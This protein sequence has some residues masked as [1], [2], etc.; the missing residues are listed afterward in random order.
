MSNLEIE[1]VLINNTNNIS[2]KT[3]N[4]LYR[5]QS[6]TH[7]KKKKTNSEFLSEKL[8]PQINERFSNVSLLKSLVF[9]NSIFTFYNLKNRK[10]NK[11]KEIQSILGIDKLYGDIMIFIQD[12]KTHYFNC[13]CKDTFIEDLAKLVDKFNQSS[14]CESEIISPN[15][16]NLI[17]EDKTINTNNRNNTNNK[18]N[19]SNKS[20]SINNDS[21]NISKILSSTAN[22][23]STSSN[24]KSGTD[25]VKVTKQKGKTEVS[26]TSKR[27]SKKMS[28][29]V[30]NVSVNKDNN[31]IKEDECNTDIE[32]DLECSDLE[33]SDIEFTDDEDA[34][35]TTQSTN[36]TKN[37]LN[38]DVD[39]DIEDLDGGDTDVYLDE[40][41]DDDNNGNDEEIEGIDDE[42][43]DNLGE[44]E[45]DD[46]I[47][48]EDNE[49]ETNYNMNL[50]SSIISGT[51]IDSLSNSVSD[52][53]EEKK[54]K[55][56]KSY[57]FKN[58]FSILKDIL[59]LEEVSKLTPIKSLNIIRKNNIKIL[60]KIP[61][62]SKSIRNIEQGIY[63]YSVMRCE[64]NYYMPNWESIEFK[65]SYINKSRTVFSNLVSNNYIGNDYLLNKIKD[66]SIDCYQIAFMESYNLFPSKWQDIIDEKI[67]I[68]QILKNEL[69]GTASEHFK[70]PKCKAR[71][72]IY[73]Q[74]QT[75]SADEPM[76]TFITCLKCGNKWKQ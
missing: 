63:N 33:C 76:T 25:K 23:K 11:S 30:N 43:D 59:T 61:I 14:T 54:K 24:K 53:V 3:A 27:E 66:K 62:N 55:K 65:N 48:D 41:S 8:E 70:C 28:N 17:S 69:Q 46:D 52:N 31:I 32:L 2:I 1:Y 47:D 74:V 37:E 26:D 64:E 56:T 49:L 21:D 71:K 36:N 18:N 51:L 15:F 35:S 13:I 40:D 45:G 75:R 22:K 6:A 42:L 39:I 29:E 20:D 5:K 68:E 4:L 38:E 7:Y 12:V 50:N 16:K 73:V 44:L 9:E 72:T 67:K 19:I 34:T 57:N 60:S 58:N 10:K